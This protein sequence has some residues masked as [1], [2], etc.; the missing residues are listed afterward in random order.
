MI[1]HRYPPL[2]SHREVPAFVAWIIVLCSW[3]FLL[4]KWEGEK[5][6]EKRMEEKYAA[7]FAAT[8][9]SRDGALE[10]RQR[11]LDERDRAELVLEDALHLPFIDEDWDECIQVLYTEGGS[12][13]CRDRK[14]IMLPR[15][16]V[17]G[18][19]SDGKTGRSCRIYETDDLR[20]AIQYIVQPNLYASNPNACFDWDG[21]FADKKIE[22]SLI[23]GELSFYD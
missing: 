23:C 6:T 11:L 20:S 15:Y 3:F 7:L 14:S 17:E 1:R 18:F 9:A 2:L 10:E 13:I 22:A 21:Y 4:G 12:A 19:T 16:Y 5:Q 8:N